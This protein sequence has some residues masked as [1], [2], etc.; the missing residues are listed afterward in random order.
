MLGLTYAMQERWAEAEQQMRTAVSLQP[1]GTYS[2]AMLAYVLA[3]TGRTD[4]A[5]AVQRDIEAR[6]RT[7]YVSPVAFATMHLGFGEWDQAFDQM[8]RARAERRGWMAYLRVNPIVDPLR[9][10]PRFAVQ[11]AAMKL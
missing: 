10:H 11:L 5:R 6:A 1:A 9:D 3:R 8:D 2:P 7:D 4:E